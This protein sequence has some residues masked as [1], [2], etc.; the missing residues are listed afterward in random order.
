[1]RLD[2]EHARLNY[3][4][5]THTGYSI[6]KGNTGEVFAHE[7]IDIDDSGTLNKDFFDIMGGLQSMAQWE[8][9]SM[10]KKDKVHFTVAGYTL[11]GDLLYN[12]LIDRYIKHITHYRNY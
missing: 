9:Q 8:D 10:A 1:M 5:V 11:I 12:A 3:R 6:L 7:A 4:S 2:Y